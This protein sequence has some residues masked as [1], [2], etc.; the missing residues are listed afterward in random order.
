MSSGLT[1]CTSYDR[2]MLDRAVLWRK[3]HKRPD[4]SRPRSRREVG[5]MFQNG[6]RFDPIKTLAWLVG[7]WAGP[8]PIP[9][10]GIS[11]VVY[12]TFAS[13]NARRSNVTVS[14]TGP[15]RRISN[16]SDVGNVSAFAKIGHPAASNTLE[17]WIASPRTSGSFATYAN[18][19][20]S[21]LEDNIAA[22]LSPVGFESTRQATTCFNRSCSRPCGRI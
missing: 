17:S 9:G 11:S 5:V 8:K 12:G 1:G 14:F 10:C 18:S 2:T 16:T 6:G 19:I 3:R 13:E 15:G 20:V 22:I 21:F 7:G 4:G